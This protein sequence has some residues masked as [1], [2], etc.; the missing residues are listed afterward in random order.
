M[1]IAIYKDNL[2]TGR[3][4][5]RAVKNFAAGLSERG[6][7]VSLMEKAEFFAR[8]LDRTAADT[9]DSGDAFEI[10]VATGP[11]EIVDMDLAGYFARPDRARVVL[12]LHLAPRGFFKWRHPLRNYRIRRA[13]NKADSAQVLCSSY[14]AEFR[15]LAPHPRL[16]AIGNYTDTPMRPSGPQESK[17]VILYPAAV[18]N[19]VKNQKLLI[20]AFAHVADAFPSW[21]VRLL[22]KSSTPYA[23]ACR[24]LVEKKGLAG[25][26]EFA[27]FI[28]DMA[29][30][31]DQAAFV[32]FP[33]TLEGFP[34]ALL[35]AAQS[36]L[37]AV[38]HK[39]LPGAEDIIRD[40]RTGLLTA[41]NEVAYAEGLR[42][43][44]SDAELRRKMGENAREF[45]AD[46][47]SR[48][49]I[50]DQWEALLG[51]TAAEAPSTTL[52]GGR[53]K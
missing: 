27:G 22:G 36:G 26:V 21:R 45:C 33:S 35:D 52:P 42:R 24:R 30:A 44:M 51:R 34:L 9:R 16:Y 28:D 29:S 48:E 18:V 15:R 53:W 17:N 6:L 40:G 39:A 41:P 8:V 31:Y 11:N 12:Q 3:G 5:D 14:E 47:Y 20:A 13:F 2:S 43:L 4:A 19:R 32:A 46:Q 37:C 10:I 38:A 25:R 50:F 49:R 7:E 23:D 1:K